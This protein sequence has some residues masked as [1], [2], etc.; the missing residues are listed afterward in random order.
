MFF[1]C[2]SLMYLLIVLLVV[3]II[4]VVIIACIRG[5]DHG[6]KQQ[7]ESFE[8]IT[9][10]DTTSYTNG[11]V[12]PE[13]RANDLIYN[14]QSLTEYMNNL[15]A[16]YDKL[17]NDKLKELT[18]KVDTKTTELT[19]T[20]NTKTRE[21][22][23]TVNTKTRE[24]TNTVNTKTKELTTK[25]D[26][27]KKDLLQ[28]IIYPVGSV[29]I[30]TSHDTNPKDILG[31]GVWEQI[32][33]CMLYACK[34]KKT[35]EDFPFINDF[36]VFDKNYNTL[37]KDNVYTKR[38]F[39]VNY[40]MDGDVIDG[41]LFFEYHVVDKDKDTTNKVYQTVNSNNNFKYYSDREFKLRQLLCNMWVRIK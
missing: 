16:T 1:F 8:A 9:K 40:E 17:V 38:Y 22:T 21:L 41:R 20:V 39:D 14:G 15:K 4:I 32:H 31:F 3:V 34:M 5:C 6:C 19:N 23:N 12:V 29:Y 24:L 2:Q 7:C 13:I 35:D 37:F 36:Y 26:N 28:N 11:V 10:G 30:T 25:V 27:M 18:T 33:E